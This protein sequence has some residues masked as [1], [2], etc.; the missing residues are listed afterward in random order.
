MKEH[1]R[2]NSLRLQGYDYS[3][4]GIYFITIRAKDMV[5]GEVINSEMRLNEYGRIAEEELIKKPRFAIL[6]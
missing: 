3:R 1:T 6:N 5:F 2:R 4:A